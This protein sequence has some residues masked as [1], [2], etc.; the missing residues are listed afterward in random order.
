MNPILKYPFDKRSFYTR[1]DRKDIGFG[2]ELWRGIFQSFRP[3]INRLILNIDLKAGV[4]YKEGPLL[5][6]CL[7]FF[8]KRDASPTALFSSDIF[9]IKKR[10]E[11][12]R[13]LVGLRV[14]TPTTGTKFRTIR[15]LSDL[16]AETHTFLTR[17]GTQTTV[18]QY[19]ASLGHQLRYP[20]VICIQVGLPSK[21]RFYVV[22]K[23][24]FPGRS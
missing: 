9:P 17:S 6:L 19:F 12:R 11:L 1:Q 13:F 8:G 2:L 10:L 14:Q 3:T 4:M 16:G 24:F 23:Q 5:S 18:A 21:Y 20:S 15:G 22:L 7:D